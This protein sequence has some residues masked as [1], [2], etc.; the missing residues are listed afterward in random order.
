MGVI[1]FGM[2]AY[3]LFGL[4]NIIESKR[5][6]KRWKIAT[7][8]VVLFIVGYLYKIYEII[9]YGPM[10]LNM[11]VSFIYFFGAMFVEI[12]ISTTYDTFLILNEEMTKRKKLEKEK[13]DLNKR[14]TIIIKK[15]KVKNK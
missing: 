9:I 4:L 2:S 13:N 8:L 12:V 10:I 3:Y 1:L 14:L 15:L 6:L 5:A 7:W 11:T